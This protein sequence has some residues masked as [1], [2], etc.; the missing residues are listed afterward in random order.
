MK[1]ILLTLIKTGLPIA[2]IAVMFSQGLRLALAQQLAFFKEHSMVMARSLL[3]V[4]VL[5]PLVA[6]SVV[7]ILRPS[8]AVA[9]GL[10]ILASSPAAPFQ[11]LNIAK[12]GGSLVY[13]ATLHLT[14]AL[15]AIITV[16][17]TL[18]LLTHLFGFKAEFSVLAVAETVATTILI[19]VG[20]GILVRYFL[21]G[22]AD[23]IGPILGKLGEIALYLLIIPVLIKAFSL[24]LQISLW[25]YVSMIVFIIVN[26]AI[27]HRLGPD[28]EQERTTLAMEGSARNIGLA[29][30][31]GAL[32]F[33]QE[34]ALPV[35][36][37]YVIVFVVIST[38][39]LKW[40]QKQTAK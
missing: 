3:A 7:A 13:L 29:L 31:I 33:S 11:L 37:P 12:K 23:K 38:I 35:F 19:P 36:L 21:P 28:D 39:Y 9:I 5:V 2:L 27:C 20:L 16:P 10:L 4:L 14:L 25:S 26:L 8:P 22:V 40:R 17:V 34:K 24:M 32:N 15:F 18:Y 30:T 6:L 1:D